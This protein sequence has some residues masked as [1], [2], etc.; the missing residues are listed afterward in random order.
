MQARSPRCWRWPTPA[1][2]TPVVC[3]PETP[4]PDQTGGCCAAVVRDRRRRPPDDRR[5]TG[6]QRHCNAVAGTVATPRRTAMNPTT[7][8][9]L[10]HATAWLIAGTAATAQAG[11][12]RTIVIEDAVRAISIA[13]GVFPGDP[14][15]FHFDDATELPVGPLTLTVF[16]TGDFDGLGNDGGVIGGDDGALEVFG[17]GLEFFNIA[18]DGDTDIGPFNGA[19][20]FSVS[21]TVG[22]GAQYFADGLVGSI[23]LGMGVDA[24][25][26]GDFLAM[27]LQYD[28]LPVPEPAPSA[29][30]LGGL[31]ALWFRR[32]LS[33]VS[34]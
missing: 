4:A 9:L 29:M 11:Y 31:A 14:F 20:S 26:P 3:A 28:T 8:R 18:L 25:Q 1:N 30:L 16:G 12:D 7:F 6:L 13:S 22:M 24:N 2:A 21:G 5:S 17:V 33:P 23:V 15:L 34:G 27:R 32:R 19:R 10:R